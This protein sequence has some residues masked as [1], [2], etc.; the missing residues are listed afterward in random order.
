M[1]GTFLEQWTTKAWTDEEK[2]ETSEA[3]KEELYNRNRKKLLEIEEQLRELG[4][5]L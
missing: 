3:I 2:E 4:V 5:E 1:R